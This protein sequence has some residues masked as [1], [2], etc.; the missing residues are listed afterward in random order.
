MIRSSNK[1][2]Q[3]ASTLEEVGKILQTVIR[4][5]RAAGM[6]EKNIWKL[7]TSL[8]EACTNIVCYGYKGSG[9]GAISVRW[10]VD[11]DR[12]IVTIEDQGVPFDQTEPTHPDFDCDICKRKIGGLG[13]F[14]MSQFLDDM[15][16][17][18]MKGKNRL[19]LIKNLHCEE[20]IEAEKVSGAAKIKS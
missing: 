16:Y 2:I 8:D 17:Q 4:A 15:I 19:I 18:R 20:E 7:E 14:I 12:F 6:A 13:R 9:N 5:A 3:C 1:S 11:E 10:E